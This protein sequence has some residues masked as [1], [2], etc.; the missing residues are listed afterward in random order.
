MPSPLTRPQTC[1]FSKPHLAW[2]TPRIAYCDC[3]GL[4]V[5]YDGLFGQLLPI[6]GPWVREALYFLAQAGQPWGASSGPSLCEEYPLPAFPPLPLLADEMT[7][8]RAPASLPE[9][10]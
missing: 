1:G 8:E 4:S 10:P 2:I 7:V 6:R 9:R 3:M 5:W